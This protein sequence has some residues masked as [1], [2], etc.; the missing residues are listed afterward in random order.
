MIGEKRNDSKLGFTLI[1]LIAV[2]ALLAVLAIILFPIVTDSV[3]KSKKEAFLV[4]VNG[5][6]RAVKTNKNY[7]SEQEY[8]IENGKITPELGV[9]GDIEGNG[10]IFVDMNGN[11][12]MIVYTDDYCAV[13]DFTDKKVSLKD[14]DC[15]NYE[16]ILNRYL[17]GKEVYF[18]PY[19][20]VV[21]QASQAWTQ[22]NTA[23]Q[24]YKWN[25]VQ[26][27]DSTVELLLDHNLIFKIAWNVDNRMGP[28]SALMNQLKTL[29]SGFKNVER[30]TSSDNETHDGA[31]ES[32]YTI[33]YE[34]SYAK[35]PN[36]KQLAMAAKVGDLW[37]QDGD[38]VS[39]KEAPFLS[40]N[41][42]GTIENSIGYC[43]WTSNAYT[44]DMYAQWVVDVSNNLY[45]D[46][47]ARTNSNYCGIRPTIRVKKSNLK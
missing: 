42:V 33:N 19:Q 46:Y 15:E 31:E 6:F 10:K 18:N 4:S 3:E 2:I 5:I 26:N 24:C 9:R 8:T 37:K 25:V 20:G 1:E 45:N 40:Q 43:Y 30:L 28:S 12:Q 14:G 16:E 17:V 21:C 27:N 47:W 34:G 36:T 41:L 44:N 7:E 23:S 22:T 35:I 13:K 38:P 32:I 11:I 29:T 39:L